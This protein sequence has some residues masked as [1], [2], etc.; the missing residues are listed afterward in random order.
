MLEVSNDPQWIVFDVI[1]DSINAFLV[2]RISKP[3]ALP[4]TA[5]GLLFGKLERIGNHNRVRASI[6]RHIG[7]DLLHRLGGT[8]HDIGPL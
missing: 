3:E 8:R 5:M 6:L 7:D 1:E 2:D 4:A